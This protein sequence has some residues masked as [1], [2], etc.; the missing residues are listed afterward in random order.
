MASDDTIINILM[1]KFMPWYMPK[2]LC[3]QKTKLFVVIFVENVEVLYNDV[4]EVL[5]YVYHGTEIQIPRIPF[6][7]DI[8]IP[9]GTYLNMRHSI[10]CFFDILPLRV[11]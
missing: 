10:I 1:L 11:S 7:K 4:T 9:F 3:V 2:I 6:T 5:R 8:R